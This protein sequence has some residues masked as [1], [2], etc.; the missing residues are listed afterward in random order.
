MSN[1]DQLIVRIT[2]VWI[3]SSPV[4]RI[5]ALAYKFIW[6]QGTE[7]MNIYRVMR[8]VRRF[9]HE[10]PC[11]WR[12][13]PVWIRKYGY[14]CRSRSPGLPSSAHINVSV[15]SSV[16]DGRNLKTHWN[17]MNMAFQYVI[18]TWHFPLSSVLKAYRIQYVLRAQWILYVNGRCNI[19]LIPSRWQ[20]CATNHQSG[21]PIDLYI[22]PIYNIGLIIGQRQIKTEI[23]IYFTLCKMYSSR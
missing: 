16:T 15:F 18:R 13:Y 4:A 11:N 22:R 19:I 1:S 3:C 7:K 17:I 6:L 21:L 12:R 14:W 5:Q 8:Q 9:Q 10:S 23:L 20:H 2:P